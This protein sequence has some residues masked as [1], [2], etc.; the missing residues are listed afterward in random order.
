MS[1][2]SRRLSQ[3]IFVDKLLTDASPELVTEVNIGI[4]EFTKLLGNE[5]LSPETLVNIFLTSKITLKIK[6]LRYSRSAINE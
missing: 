5:I 6:N 1:N 2:T 4:A 3:R